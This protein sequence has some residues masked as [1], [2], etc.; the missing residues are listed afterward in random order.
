MQGILNMNYTAI[1]PICLLTGFALIV[2]LMDLIIRKGDRRFLGYL[3]IIAF[4][5]TLPVAL[6]THE[7]APAFGGMVLSDGYAAYF[8]VMFIMTGIFTVLISMDYLKRVNAHRGEYYYVILF[9]VIG[10]MTMASSNDLINLYVG[11]ELM[12]LSFY[13]LVAF[14][15]METKSVEGALKYFILGA[16]SSGVLLYGISFVYGFAGATNFQEIARIAMRGSHQNPF[17]LL[18]ITMIIAGFAFKVALFPFHAWAPD[19]YE[20]APTPITALLSVGS[21]AAAFAVFLRFFMVAWPSFHAQWSSVLWALSA[22][23]MLFGAVVAVMQTNIIRMLA[24]SSIA[25]AGIILIGL[26]VFTGSGSA[27]VM[28][29]LLAYIFMNMGA[30]AVVTL[31]VRD[32]GRGELISHYKGLASKRPWLA[33]A[34]ALFLVSLAGIP[35]TGGFTAKFFILSSAI[36]ARYYVIAAIGVI[37]TAISLFFYAKVIFYMYM[38]EPD[39]A[40]AFTVGECETSYKLLILVTALCTVLIGIFPAPFMEAA[41][42]AVKPFI[43]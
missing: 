19:A 41:L 21:K 11:I 7:D 28:Y 5:I 17:I 12:A 32:K 8:N 30:F 4:L 35:P 20:G 13:V 43:M 29:Y 38:K 1:I 2:L 26:I 27:S 6:L 16:L 42:N 23:T 33:F 15:V 18:A 36:S 39:E 25:H 14:R 22:V 9:A 3:T 37:S 10:M 24:Y 31:F 40:D 34:M